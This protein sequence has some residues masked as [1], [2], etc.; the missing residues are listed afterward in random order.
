MRLSIFALP[1]LA[2]SA[3]AL[4]ACNDSSGGEGGGG[5]GG[6]TSSDSTTT[7]LTFDENGCP[8]G[9][10]PD[11]GAACDKDAVCPLDSGKSGCDPDP[12]LVASCAGGNWNIDV[13]LACAAAGALTCDPAGKWMGTRTGDYVYSPTSAGTVVETDHLE[14]EVVKG[15]DGVLRVRNAASGNISADGCHLEVLLGGDESC[16][17]H[18]GETFCDYWSSYVKIDFSQAPVTGELHESCS[19]ECEIDATA[20]FQFEKQL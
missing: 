16:S 3:L 11:V 9:G 5:T 10:L 1:L 20:P 13:P 8:V 12:G 17:E 18:G 7:S 4:S 15:E 14:L 6:T 19:G 2:I